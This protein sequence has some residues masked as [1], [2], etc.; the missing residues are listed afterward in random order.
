MKLKLRRPDAGRSSGMESDG[1]NRAALL[2]PGTLLGRF[3]QAD[4]RIEVL[5]AAEYRLWL[6]A[7][8]RNASPVGL[9]PVVWDHYRTL[10]L[11]PV[12]DWLDANSWTATVLVVKAMALYRAVVHG[13]A[14]DP[15]LGIEINTDLGEL[16]YQSEPM[17]R[18]R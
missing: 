9:G 16:V 3:I 12:P 15:A 7:Q 10:S 17:H 18:N 8:A 13:E 2:T 6:R 1:S 11:V 5:S 14:L 4:R